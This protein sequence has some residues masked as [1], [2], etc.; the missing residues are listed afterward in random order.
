MITTVDSVLTKQPNA[1]II[2]LGDFNRLDL[3]PLLSDK[4]VQLVDQPPEM[5]PY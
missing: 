2:I 3:N 1:G 4:L 5:V